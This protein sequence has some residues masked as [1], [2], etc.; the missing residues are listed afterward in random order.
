MEFFGWIS[1]I[2]FTC[3]YLPQIIRT[4]RLKTVDDISIWLFLLVMVASLSGLVYGLWLR[5]GPLV[6]NYGVGLVL[7]SI[8]IGQYYTY[9]DPKRDK[10]RK[11]VRDTIKKVR[12]TK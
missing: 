12:R 11:I 5:E 4:H 9:K 2:C 10:I 6:F 3:C 8:I 7:S 1:A